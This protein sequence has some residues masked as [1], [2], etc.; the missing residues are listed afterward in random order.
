MFEINA[1]ANFSFPKSILG[2]EKWTKKMSKNQ[3]GRNILGKN[4]AKFTS[5]HNGLK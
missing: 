3:Y 1:V 2:F 4:I 5:D